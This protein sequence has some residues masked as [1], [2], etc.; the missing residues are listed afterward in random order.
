MELNGKRL[1]ILAGA[2]VHCK[3]IEA[4]KELGVR[5]IVTDYLTDSPGKKL[6]DECLMFSITDVDGIVEYCKQNP[7]DGVLNFCNDTAQKPYQQIC[8]RLGLPCYSTEKQVEVLTN[9]DLF[10]KTCI[11]YGVD[12]IP[13]YTEEDLQ[14]GSIEYPVV[15]K[16]TDSRGSRGVSRCSSAE[17]LTA[18]LQAAKA[19]S[20]ANRAI[21]EKC[22]YGKQDFSMTYF[23]VDGTPY[24]LR[25]G[26]RMLGLPEYGL[27]RQCSCMISPSK[28]IQMYLDC[29]ADRIKK[30]LIG[31]GMKNGPVFMQGFIDGN[32]VRVYDPGIRF[33]GGDYEKVYRRVNGADIM[34]AMVHFAITGKMEIDTAVLENGFMLNGMSSIQLDLDAAPGLIARYD[35]LDKVAA[36][37][38]VIFIAQKAFPGEQIPASGDVKQRIGEIG[39]LVP[40]RPDVIFSSIE[41]ILREIRVEDPDGKDLLLYQIDPQYFQ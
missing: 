18:A 37:P 16:P 10:K 8:S 23:F 4:A 39:I 14:S 36:L 22:M 26:D 17:E 41:K 25:A 1:L 15:V 19:E 29:I 32:T 12:V 11:S 31:L 24:L 13:E 20:K 35:G 2:D 38:E 7:V 21:I 34:K 30:M 9:K 28:H 6:A 27:D 33:P 5:T 3:V 40:N